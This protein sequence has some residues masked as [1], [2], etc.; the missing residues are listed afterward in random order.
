MEE[1][2]LQDKLKYNH[3]VLDLA[4][5]AKNYLKQGKQ[6]IPFAKKTLELILEKTNS[7][8][9]WMVNTLTDPEVISKTIES[10]LSTYDQCAEEESVSEVLKYYSKDFDTY[11]GDNSKIAKEKLA[12]FMD[13]NYGKIKKQVSA[14]QNVIENKKENDYGSKQEVENA[15]KTIEKYAILINTLEMLRN[16]NHKNFSNEVEDYVTKESFKKMYSPKEEYNSDK[17]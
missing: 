3:N 8:D 12:P 5:V 9:P 1:E 6:G 2:R 15:K 17:E 16:Q 11:I 14:A 4:N 7:T 13:E 10:Q